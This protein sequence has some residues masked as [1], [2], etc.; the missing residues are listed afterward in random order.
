MIQQAD[1]TKEVLTRF[2]TLIAKL[3]EFTPQ[4]Y[5]TLI[6]EYINKNVAQAIF[7]IFVIIM[8]TSMLVYVYNK[9]NKTIKAPPTKDTS[10]SSTKKVYF[11]DAECGVMV[12]S[13]VVSG[14][15]IVI[16]FVNLIN[17]VNHFIA[18]NYY[19]IKEIM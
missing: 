19:L 5:D 2:D 12:A 3:S 9:Y 6:R 10:Y 13:S 7:C 17:A 18:P 1:V 4:A 8:F 16:A 11:T 14:M 15:F